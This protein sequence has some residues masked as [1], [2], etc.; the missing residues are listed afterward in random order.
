VLASSPRTGRYTRGVERSEQLLRAVG[1][2]VARSGVAGVTHRAVAQEAGVSLRATTYYFETKEAMIREALRYFVR[3]NISRADAVAQ[4]FPSRSNKLESAVEAIASVLLQEA[5]D[6]DDLLRTEYELILAISREPRYAPEYQELQQ[7]LEVRLRALLAAIGSA[8]P[9][10]HARIVLATTRGLQ[11]EF[12]A[13][14][15][16]RPSD[17]S[18][19]SHLKALLCALVPASAH[20]DF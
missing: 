13:S 5:T 1:R 10:R 3:E 8:D 6:P 9:S 18:I 2:L 14:P 17:R 4:R 20:E 16:R 11:V 12:L 7:M 19:R 15:E